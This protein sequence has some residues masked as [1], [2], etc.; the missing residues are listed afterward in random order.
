MDVMRV[1]LAHILAIV[2]FSTIL[3]KII[4]SSQCLKWIKKVQ[5]CDTINNQ[6]MQCLLFKMYERFWFTSNVDYC[7]YYF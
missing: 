4:Y 1:F 7:I 3:L 6:V 5:S 2:F